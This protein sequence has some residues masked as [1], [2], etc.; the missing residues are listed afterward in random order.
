[1]RFE[2][3]RVGLLGLALAATGCDGAIELGVGQT[4]AL[5]GTPA[6]PGTP[7][8]PTVPG[9]PSNPTRPEDVVPVTPPMGVTLKYE[10]TDPGARGTGDDRMRRL[11]TPHLTATLTTLLGASVMQNAQVRAQLEQL[12]TDQASSSVTEIGEGHAP[13]HAKAMLEVATQAAEL[14][15]A[16]PAARDALFG[17]CA[18]QATVTD[19]CA[20]TFIDGFG[21][22][23]WRRPLVANEKATLLAQFKAQGGAEGLKRVLMRILLAPELAFHVELG[24]MKEGNR[25][26]LSD[27]EIANR[28]SYRIT[29]EPPDA[30]LV[31]AADK[32]ELQSLDAVKAHTRRLFETP[33]AKANVD[34]MFGYWLTLGKVPDPKRLAHRQLDVG[35]LKAEM[36]TELDD[37]ID[38]VVWAKKGA[39]TDLMRSREVFPRSARMATI[40][41]AMQAQGTTP[42]TTSEAHAGLLLRPALLAGGGERTNPMH[43]GALIRRRLLCV[44]LGAP[45]ANAVAAR[46][47]EVGDVTN[48]PN[49]EAYTKLTNVNQCLGCHNQLNPAGFSLE[50]YDQLGMVRTDEKIENAQG[51]VVKT[52]AID[53]QVTDPRLTNEAG[54][55]TFV[56]GADFARGL[57]RSDDARAC[58]AK[59]LFEFQRLRASVAADA[60]ALREVENAATPAGSVVDALVTSIANADIFW[61]GN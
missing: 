22:K 30:A 32:G 2:R 31:A 40:L 60:C 8:V 15:F 51:Q 54:G 44:N 47:E 14:A 9:T 34:A 29:G 26:R 6:T 58:F 39:F 59:T 12:A 46:Q 10:C 7:G 17:S 42:A 5:P 55:N 16:T 37:F 49:R 13:T 36:L 52:F 57:A 33:Q 21:R 28:L 41:E 23:A 61:R 48:L 4:P 38:H 27:H 25:V 11:L 50:N 20:Q 43:R 56:D 1:M 53:S 3:L 19:A 18:G 24:T 35:G 45:D